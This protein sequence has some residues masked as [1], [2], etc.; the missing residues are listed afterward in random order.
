[1]SAGATDAIS[2]AL[3]V[4]GNLLVF[5]AMVAFIDAVLAFFGDLVSNHFALV[6]KYLG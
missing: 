2:L 6:S 1:M 5:I 4:A 3:N